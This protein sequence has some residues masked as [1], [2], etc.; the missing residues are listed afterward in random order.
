MHY[1]I[2]RFANYSKKSRVTIYEYGTL[3]FDHFSHH[4]I[5]FDIKTSS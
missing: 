4:I 2:G 3:K 1:T 5:K